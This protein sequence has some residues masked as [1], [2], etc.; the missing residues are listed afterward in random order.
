MQMRFDGYIGFPGGL[1]D[2]GENDVQALNR[3]LQ[4]ECNFR[5][6]NLTEDNYV[7]SFYDEKKRLLCSL[8][9]LLLSLKEFEEMERDVFNAQDF[10]DEVIHF[11]IIFL[12]EIKEYCTSLFLM[13]FILKPKISNEI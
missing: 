8:Y 7:V 10:G 9:T 3:E 13:C 5:M 2:E 1:V 11:V 6:Y 4:E 12:V